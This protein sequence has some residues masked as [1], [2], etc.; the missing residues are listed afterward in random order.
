MMLL[1]TLAREL[2]MAVKSVK[3][4]EPIKQG[5]A[6]SIEPI[7]PDEQTRS[8]IAEAAYYRALQRGFSPGYEL[9]DWLTAEEQ[10]RR[11]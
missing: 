6:A 7:L 8:R 1:H 11:G 10:I 3:K 2:A 9:E 4:V 5:A